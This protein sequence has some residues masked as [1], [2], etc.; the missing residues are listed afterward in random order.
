MVSSDL[1]AARFAREAAEQGL[2]VTWRPVPAFPGFYDLPAAGDLAQVSRVGET[3]LG[4]CGVETI[5]NVVS[6]LGSQ[7]RRAAVE[8]VVF[9]PGTVTASVQGTEIQLHGGVPRELVTAIPL[10]TGPGFHS[11]GVH[12]TGRID[13]ETDPTDGS[14]VLLQARLEPVITAADRLGEL[15]ATAPLDEEQA[16][17]ELN[18]T[19]PVAGGRSA[20]QFFLDSTPESVLSAQLLADMVEMFLDIMELVSPVQLTSVD[21]RVVSLSAVGTGVDTGALVAAAG[22]A[23]ERA[24]QLPAWR[25]I[26]HRAREESGGGPVME[27][28]PELW[29]TDANLASAQAEL[30]AGWMT[31]Q[32]PAGSDFEARI[33]AVVTKAIPD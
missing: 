11:V 10:I 17:R 23:A 32:E 28:L 5:L 29:V 30:W 6:L 4:E 13:V 24:R 3:S 26:H 9:S 27:P 2:P 12:A 7:C 20:A 33:R 16:R 14:A 18:L 25:E 15:L 8:G 21:S 1:L 31:A 22:R 19:V